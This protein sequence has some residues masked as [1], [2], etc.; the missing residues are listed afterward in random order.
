MTQK[1]SPPRGVDPDHWVIRLITILAK[2]AIVY[3][4]I[5]FVPWIAAL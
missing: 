3:G 5:R 2:I 4:M 1:P